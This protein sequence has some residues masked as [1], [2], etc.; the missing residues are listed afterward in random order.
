MPNDINKATPKVTFEQTSSRTMNI[1]NK[2][3]LDMGS[4]IRVIMMNSDFVTNIRVSERPTVMQTNAGLN[5]TKKRNILS[6]SSAMVV[7]THTN[8]LQII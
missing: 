4:T 7:Y 8:H 6:S 3:L 2:L 5:V 1:K